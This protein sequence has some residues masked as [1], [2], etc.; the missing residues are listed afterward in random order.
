MVRLASLCFVEL[1]VAR[2]RSAAPW[3]SKLNLT[4]I[5]L[6]LQDCSLRQGKS[7]DGDPSAVKIGKRP[8]AAA[9]E[10]PLR[11]SKRLAANPNHPID[12]P[13]ELND[14]NDHDVRTGVATISPDQVVLKS[15]RSTRGCVHNDDLA[16]NG[17]A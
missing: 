12:R 13:T 15:A 6:F 4:I 16:L 14:P 3:L 7:R 8:R 11:R 17:P 9:A 2:I 1:L 5:F 10:G